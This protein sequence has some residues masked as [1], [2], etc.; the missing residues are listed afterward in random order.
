MK[1]QTV[2]EETL[3]RDF[4]KGDLGAFEVLLNRYRRPLFGYISRFVGNDRAEDIFQETFYRVIRSKDSYKVRAKFSTWLFTI[5]HNV[6]VDHL[7]KS[8][9]VS[10][11]SI[12]EPLSTSTDGTR[13]YE[14][15]LESGDA[16]PSEKSI[17]E[18]M[19]S[20]I[21]RLILELPEPQRQVLLLRQFGDM[22]FKEIAR[23]VGCRVNTAKSRM[24]YALEALRKDLSKS[25]LLS[26]VQKQ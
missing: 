12:S 2:S 21:E 18:E 17:D 9:R 10:L 26:E 7:R 4:A 19:N 11:V 3:M 23:T 1:E 5:A 20:C 25:S 8:G 16:G 14:D 15:T 22:S 13:T 24:R 6:C